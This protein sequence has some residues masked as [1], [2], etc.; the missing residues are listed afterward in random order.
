MTDRANEDVAGA[1]EPVLAPNENASRV[2]KPVRPAKEERPVWLTVLLALLLVAATIAAY[3]KIWHAGFIWDDDVYVINN[4]LLTAADGLK[5]IWFSL[6][7]PSQYFPL[8]YTSFRIEHALWGLNPVGYH[9]VNL[10]LHA[11]NA[12]ILWRL[13]TLLRVP[14][15]WLAAGLFALHPVQVESVAWITERKNVLM[16][17]FFLLALV[18]WVK[19][20]AGKHRGELKFYLLA[21][22][23]Y[24]LAL[25]AKTTACTLPVALLLISWLKR[26]K[27]ASERWFQV[28]PFVLIGIGMGIVSIW[29][30][31]F[32]Q[33]TQ[34]ELFALS[35][36]QRIVVASHAFW[37]YLGKLVWP[38]HLAFSYPRWPLPAGHW[39]DYIWL[40][41]I[42]VLIGVILV[43]RRFLG[44]SLE[45]ALLFFAATLSPVLGFI[46]LYTFRY[47]FVADHY[48]YLACIGPLT[49]GAAAIATA[50]RPLGRARNFVFPI[51]AAGL[52]GALG[53]LTWRQAGAYLNEETLWRATLAVNPSSW[54]A[55]NN[56]GIQLLHSGRGDEAIAQ[57][58]EALRLDPNYAEGHYNLANALMRGGRLDEARAHYER[59]L[60][61][62]PRYAGAHGN[63]AMLLLQLGQYDEAIAH[64]KEAI[65]I[66]PSSAGRRTRLAETLLRLG[67]SDEANAEF[68]AALAIDPKSIETHYKIALSLLRAGRTS[69]ALAHLQR[70]VEINP[71][72]AAAHNNYGNILA[73]LGQE[74]E[75]LG[76]F[77]QALALD[78]R[79]AETHYNLANALL[80]R[81]RLEE[82]I[83]QYQTALEIRP[84]Y[85]GA[86]NNLGN[87]LA[88][89][90]R[91][92]EAIAQYE[93]ALQLNPNY[94]NAHE[95]L[96]SALNSVG[97]FD[98]A[99]TH[100][101]TAWKLREQARSAPPPTPE[102]DE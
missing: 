88:Q 56:L 7:S 63:F 5:R 16:G 15:A 69:E 14:G 9:W 19:F 47:S 35:S 55:H 23:C 31:R 42:V 49:L 45:V 60:Q 91:F 28:I 30:E 18:A 12:F 53:F 96:A 1:G 24:A 62:I 22:L 64:M 71:N 50:L 83:A 73:E 27:I 74:E 81:H 82:A 100:L 67:R 52:L 65:K 78:P 17:F 10:L 41:A 37:F 59:A 93:K 86:L 38:V 85:P 58:E 2:P 3:Q 94:A 39:Q 79:N 34:G 48:Q 61:L 25:S 68:E 97:R 40:G 54:M 66:D 13:L 90:G 76:Q 92:Q 26:G 89:S 36:S 102:P 57:F 8:V 44:R 72:N 87:T 101:Q 84:N 46:M 33:G 80:G 4:P 70:M 99:M 51:L 20:V 75:A 95:N 32:H 21:L 77:N 29:W 43:A 11:A 98:E 6:D